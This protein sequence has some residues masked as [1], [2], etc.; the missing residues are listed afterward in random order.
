M[1]TELVDALTVLRSRVA[2]TRLALDVA[3]AGPGR[4]ERAQVLDQLDDYLLPR[5]RAE[6][7]PLLV[8]VGGSTG[9]GK[10]TLV[11]SLL[12]E[13]VT[14]S[15]VLRPT[16]RW[17]VLVHHPLDARW[18]STD[19]VL[20]GLARLVGARVDL[21][22]SPTDG[23][24]TGASGVAGWSGRGGVA[25]GPAAAG[26]A[27]GDATGTGTGETGTD[28]HGAGLRLVASPA[29]P[30]GLALLDAPDIDSVVEENRALA[31][32]LLAA[33]DLWLFVTT[34]A[35]YADAVPWELLGAA[36]RRRVHLALVLDR[37]DDGTEA[38]VSAHLRQMLDEHDLA[39]ATVLLV[40]E[41]STDGGLLPEVAVGA[42]ADWLTALGGD[43]AARA[44]V[45]RGTREGVTR[46]VLVRAEDLARA[47]DD[48]RAADARLR[49]AVTAAYEDAATHVERA[50]SDGTMLRGEVLARWQDVVGTGEFLRAVEQKVSGLRDRITAA[51]R[52]QR[53][54]EPALAHAIGH[55][56]EAVVL[57]AAEDAAERAHSA[58]RT[59]PAG[60]ALL[61]G[62]AL[63][64]A[65]GDLRAQVAEQIRAWQSD[66]LALVEREGADKR[67]TA[68]AVSYGV[69]GLG[70]ALM[71]A[72]FASTGGLTGAEVGIA[73]GAAILAQRLLEAV[74][75]D[76]AV[77][78]LAREAHERLAVRVRAVLAGQAARFTAQL[79]A[80]G[81]ADASG[82]AL[83]T[84][85]AQ[86]TTAA[87]RAEGA[88]AASAADAVGAGA[89]TETGRLRGAGVLARLA[90]E[91]GEAA[92]SGGA[93]GPTTGGARDRLTPA[94]T[95]AERSGAPEPER[96]PEGRLRS[97]WRRVTGAPQDGPDA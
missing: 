96:Q 34:A 61:E 14:T 45:I 87:A 48:Q 67:T 75:G 30:P 62:L 26:S 12:G 44:R 52:G 83:R 35:R 40:P 76:E 24:R 79:D 16:T 5:L 84:A 51:F 82:D 71:V 38:L 39:E 57:D 68:R 46:D 43:P 60:V 17:P 1:H 90:A 6:N 89:G 70:A 66:V 73:G 97:W 4:V 63:S 59:D 8:V 31:T 86:V 42:V 53:A 77:R 10:S 54:P 93:H 65:S 80:L 29:L 21:A 2:E 95:S 94:G 32:Q 55:G 92:G 9:A 15:G 41:T 47:S 69:N 85:V 18:F 11:N 23:G 88:A 58:W 3:S 7:A 49:A 50:T 81:T 72:V 13:Q 22:K 33:A 91:R 78:Q 20:P 27:A 25:G 74:F 28:G 37:V 36:A 64:R 19:R 56:L